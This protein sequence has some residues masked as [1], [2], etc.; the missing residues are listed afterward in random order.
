MKKLFLI[1]CFLLLTSNAWAMKFGDLDIKGDLSTANG[2]WELLA[3][4]DDATLQYGDDI[5]DGTQTYTASTESQGDADNAADGNLGTYWRSADSTSQW[6]AS[7]FAS[8]KTVTKYSFFAYDHH[9]WEYVDSIVFA[10]SANGSDWTDIDTWTSS[11]SKDTAYDR[12]VTNS[13]SYIYYRVTLN[14]GTSNSAPVAAIL[15]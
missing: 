2:R 6:W 14:L 10:G 9:D 1:I 13:T 5:I 3:D 8:G 12:A 11:W 4:L 7:Q 15:S